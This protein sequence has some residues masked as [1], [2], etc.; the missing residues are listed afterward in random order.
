MC[1]SWKTTLTLCNTTTKRMFLRPTRSANFVPSTPA[2]P[3]HYSPQIEPNVSSPIDTLSY[4]HIYRIMLDQSHVILYWN[5]MGVFYCT[6]MS[7][8]QFHP[9][10]NVINVYHN[11]KGE[12][13]KLEYDHKNSYPIVSGYELETYTWELLPIELHW[14]CATIAH[15]HEVS[16]ITRPIVPPRELSGPPPPIEETLLHMHLRDDPR[17]RGEPIASTIPS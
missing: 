12:P 7:P 15:F 11:S 10:E 13:M 17:R 3:R 5:D 14:V 8:T 4:V 9:F 6:I 2:M 1:V 16:A